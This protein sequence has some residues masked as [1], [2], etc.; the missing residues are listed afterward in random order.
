[1]YGSIYKLKSPLTFFFE[2]YFRD[3]EK[4][5]GRK[6]TSMVGGPM[7]HRGEESQADSLLGTEPDTG[8]HPNTS[9]IMT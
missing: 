3:R 9:Q 7:G 1:M 8:L 2:I 6:C 5:G 4:E